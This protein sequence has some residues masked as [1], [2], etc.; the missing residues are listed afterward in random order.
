MLDFGNGT[1]NVQPPDKIFISQ[2]L[3]N[4]QHI[5]LGAWA[6]DNRNSELWKDIV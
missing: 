1:G 6:K 2:Q 3:K 4:W 5:Q